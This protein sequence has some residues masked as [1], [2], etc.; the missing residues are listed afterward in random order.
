MK[1]KYGK[2]AEAT[3]DTTPMVTPQRSCSSGR[4]SKFI[5]KKPA[6][7]EGGNRK[8]VT[9]EKILTTLFWSM[10]TIPKVASSRNCTLL[11]RKV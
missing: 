8:T 5:P 6:M 3:I 9:T 2:T 7:N 10:L 1:Y 11:L 4:R